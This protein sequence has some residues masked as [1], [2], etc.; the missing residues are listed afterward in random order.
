MYA[1]IDLSKG[2]IVDD[3]LQAGNNIDNDKIQN[4]LET[5]FESVNVAQLKT[6][7]ELRI[8]LDRVNKL[9]FLN[10]REQ[11]SRSS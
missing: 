10:D 4:Q 1:V 8:E 5:A 11:Y 3:T 2:L 9:T 6:Y 7:L